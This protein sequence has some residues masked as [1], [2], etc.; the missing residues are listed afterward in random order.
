MNLSP[1]ISL[2]EKL[3]SS[4][5][6][7]L[8]HCVGIRFSWVQRFRTVLQYYSTCL[9]HIL[10]LLSERI[11]LCCI[12]FIHLKF[13]TSSKSPNLDYWMKCKNTSRFETF[14]HS[15]HLWFQKYLVSPDQNKLYS[16]VAIYCIKIMNPDD[17]VIIC[18]WCVNSFRA[19]L[20]ETSLINACENL[21]MLTQ[22]VYNV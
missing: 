4:V 11:S 9:R 20:S 14:V 15:S 22:H 5:I 16:I 10:I 21:V 1:T 19:F 12:V 3:H 8:V 17:S 13:F 6:R 2:T 7:K 18:Y